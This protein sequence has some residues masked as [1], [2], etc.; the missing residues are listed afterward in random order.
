MG[1]VTK[2]LPKKKSRRRRRRRR[3]RRGFR[4]TIVQ[5]GWIPYVARKSTWIRGAD[6]LHAAA[7]K[8]WQGV[9]DILTY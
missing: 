5:G 6:N 4:A 2:H 1:V 8:N 7:G 9:E 3:Y